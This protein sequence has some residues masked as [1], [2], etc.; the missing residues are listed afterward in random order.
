MP[1]MLNNSLF[2]IGSFCQH[3]PGVLSDL[4][5]NADLLYAFC[6][7]VTHTLWCMQSGH[8]PRESFCP[9]SASGNER[10]VQPRNCSPP[11]SPMCTIVS[12]CMALSA[13]TM[14]RVRSRA[15]N[16]CPNLPLNNPAHPGRVLLQNIGFINFS[17][18]KRRSL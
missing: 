12:A 16:I 14:G 15:P 7:K 3:F 17:A 6:E 2:V 13:L 11:S 10:I 8:C 5:A 18:V 1:T 9:S 4:R